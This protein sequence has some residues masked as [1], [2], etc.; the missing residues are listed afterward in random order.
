MAKKIKLPNYLSDETKTV[1]QSIIKQLPD[2]V[3]NDT[4]SLSIN[5]LAR[6]YELMINAYRDIIENGLVINDE[7][8]LN[9]NIYKGMMISIMSLIKDFGLSPKARKYIPELAETK[10]KT[11]LEEFLT[12][13]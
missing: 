11:R 13:G 6:N 2:N 10:E 1:I 12:N 5:M 9:Y 7:L 8:N 3:I 4:D